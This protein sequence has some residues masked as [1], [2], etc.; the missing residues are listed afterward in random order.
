M[1]GSKADYLE[2]RVLDCFLRNT[3]AGQVATVYLALF[4]ANPG[5]A[6]G[7]TEVSGGS[8]ARTAVTFGAASSGAVSNNADVTFPTATANWGTVSHFV[9][10]DASSG[11]NRL[12]HGDFAVAKAVNNGDTAK[13]LTGELDITED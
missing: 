9:V 8:Y 2:N 3:A 13:V 12:Y 5:E 11:G 1:A 10:F 6:A 7:G 4:T